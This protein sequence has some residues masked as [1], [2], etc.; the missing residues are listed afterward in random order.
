MMWDKDL[1]IKIIVRCLGV[2]VLLLSYL[3]GR[4]VSGIFA[5]VLIPI[6]LELLFMRLTDRTEGLRVGNVFHRYYGKRYEKWQ[7]DTKDKEKNKY[8]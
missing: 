5:I 4:Y 8:W 3:L 6:G 1:I 7:A 2:V